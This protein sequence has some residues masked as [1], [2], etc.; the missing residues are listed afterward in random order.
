M[1][2]SGAAQL[3]TP[4]FEMGSNAR[5]LQIRCLCAVLVLGATAWISCAHAE[6]APVKDAETQKTALR[7]GERDDLPAMA[8]ADRIEIQLDPTMQKAGRKKSVSVS[9]K[10]DIAKILE[11]LKVSE[12]APSAG[13]MAYTLRFMKDDK[14]M[15]QIWVYPNGEWGVVRTGS[16]SWAQGLNK[17]LPRVLEDFLKD[18]ASAP[19]STNEK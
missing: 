2:G 13:E 16:P 8:V 1:Q 19:K 3:P 4:V 15:R 5:G 17:D 11:L 7:L 9:G 18:G 10:E 14:L 6:V 12:I